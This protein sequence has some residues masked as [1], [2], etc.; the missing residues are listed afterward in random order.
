MTV[1]MAV[2]DDNDA[3]DDD[4]DDDDNDEDDDDDDDD[5][6]DKDN[7]DCDDHADSDG[8]H[9]DN[10]HENQCEGITIA[11][12]SRPREARPKNLVYICMTMADF[13]S[14][15]FEGSCK[16]QILGF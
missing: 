5:D 14:R 9:H 4:D 11:K 3:Y 16:D 15:V 1:A 7:D 2:G 10:E 12:D 8:A 13:S 6:D